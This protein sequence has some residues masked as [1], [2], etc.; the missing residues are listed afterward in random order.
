MQRHFSRC[1]IQS[2]P[3][4][5]TSIYS[6]CLE[7]YPKLGAMDEL[8][9][10]HL[11]VGWHVNQLHSPQIEFLAL[12]GQRWYAGKPRYSDHHSRGSI[13]PSCSCCISSIRGWHLHMHKA[14]TGG[15]VSVMLCQ[16]MR[17]GGG[18][19]QGMVAMDVVGGCTW[20]VA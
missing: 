10:S 1:L 6:K 20:H 7:H 13:S 4:L 9:L 11:S 16:V 15:E 17:C 18:V 5:P 19:L 2:S 14:D 3:I 8:N 12:S